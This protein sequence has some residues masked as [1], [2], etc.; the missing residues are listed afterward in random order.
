MVRRLQEFLNIRIRVVQIRLDT[1][2]RGR[3]ISRAYR[4]P[5][6]PLWKTNPISAGLFGLL[7]I[8]AAAAGV[9]LALHAKTTVRWISHPVQSFEAKIGKPGSKPHAAIDTS[10]T[11]SAGADP[12]AVKTPPRLS[13]GSAASDTVGEDDTLRLPDSL[14]ST[15]AA[16]LWTPLST[17]RFVLFANKATSRLYLLADQRGTWRVARVYDVVTGRKSGPKAVAGDLRTPEGIYFIIGKRESDELDVTYGPLAYTLNYPN[18]HDRLE[19]RTGQGIWI[20]GT[21]PDSALA[22]SHGCIKMANDDLQGLAAI[23]QNGIGTPVVIVNDNAVA[24]PAGKC[25]FTSLKRERQRILHRLWAEN[26]A[27]AAVLE[28]WRR[29]WEAKDITQFGSC[30]AP[31]A[32]SG[33]ADRETFLAQKERTFQTYRTISIGVDSVLVSDVSDSV[34]VVKFVQHYV[35]NVSQMVNAKKLVF[36]NLDGPWKIYREVTFP[37]EELFL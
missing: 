8:L 18:D 27:F 2:R 5:G 17:M 29:A 35:S 33:G 15:A 28:Q 23:L 9:L 19:G 21:A 32:Q 7:V 34:A 25:N 16:K 11:G 22:P 14:A 30:Y 37:K 10:A 20:H 4:A 26:L 12:A 36:R 13:A 1:W 31:D 24:D 6:A 3:E